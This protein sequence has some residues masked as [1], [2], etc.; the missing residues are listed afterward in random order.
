MNSELTVLGGGKYTFGVWETGVD[1]DPSTTTVSSSTTQA[2]SSTSSSSAEP[3]ST[4]KAVTSTSGGQVVVVTKPVAAPAPAAPTET[5]KKSGGGGSNKASIAAGVVVGGVGLI[6]IVGAVFFVLR[7]RK[8]KAIEDE[9]RRTAILSNYPKSLN[10]A[11]S[12]SRFDGM[13]MAERR[14]SNGSIDDDQDFSRRILQ[15]M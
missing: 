4:T 9:Y 2:P 8:R 12:D 14:Q 15:V 11:G 7:Y 5:S 3:T 6:A 1:P 13:F 10:S